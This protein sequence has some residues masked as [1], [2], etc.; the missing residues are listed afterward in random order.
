MS[1]PAP[2]LCDICKHIEELP[3]DKHDPKKDI[4]SING[5]EIEYECGKGLLKRWFNRKCK[6][7]PDGRPEDICD[8]NF[9]HF[10]KHPSQKNDIVFEGERNGEL[11]EIFKSEYDEKKLVKQGKPLPLL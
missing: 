11:Y 1:I 3:N 8:G 5:E 6:A 9:L 7:F 2:S 4:V 10:E